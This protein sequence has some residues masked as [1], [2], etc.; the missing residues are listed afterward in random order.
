MVCLLC[1]KEKLKKVFTPRSTEGRAF[2]RCVACKTMQIS[3][4]PS[5]DDVA[6]YYEKYDVLGEQDPYYR[7]AWNEEFKDGPEL[8][9]A[10]NRL[11]FISPFLFSG[12]RLLDVGSGPG[13]F[14]RLAGEAGLAAEGVELNS[15]AA[16]RSAEKFKLN[17]KHGSIE[18]AA[19]EYDAIVLWDV[20]EHVGNPGEF[21]K[22]CSARIKNN[23]WIFVET[24][25]EAALL[26]RAVL[27][28]ARLG[29]KGPAET[30]YGM[31]HLVLFRIMTLNKLLEENG[32]TIEKAN[33]LSTD[34]GRVFRS[35]SFK[36]TM[37]RFGLGLLFFFAALFGRQNKMLVA[38]RKDK[39]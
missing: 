39:I 9:E 18:S 17:V 2:Y 19:G 10:K 23:G 26:D 29:I 34:P 1:G 12:A 3:P 13:L 22:K 21:I 14:L 33:F 4:V 30:F 11:K 7:D 35:S 24:P 20:L 31:H 32:F 36:D 28:L 15:A 38:A 6:A 27:F 37:T 5:E 16:L 8:R 25:N